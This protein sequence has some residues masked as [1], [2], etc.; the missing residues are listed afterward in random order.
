MICPK[1]QLEQPDSN[2]CIHSGVIF[3]KYQAYLVQQN[4]SKDGHNIESEKNN[5]TNKTTNHFWALNHP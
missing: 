1:C 2:P 3:A 5:L 4:K